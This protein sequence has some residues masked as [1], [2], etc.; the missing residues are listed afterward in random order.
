MIGSILSSYTKRNLTSVT[1]TGAT[2]E[3]ASPSHFDEEK[4]D[5]YH[6]DEL[7]I[8]NS[9]SNSYSVNTS[10][11]ASSR[12]RSPII[13]ISQTKRIKRRR[14]S[15]TKT[16]YTAVLPKQREKG[17]NY[18]CIARI[19]L[20]LMLVLA[21]I[22]ILFQNYQLVSYNLYQTSSASSSSASSSSNSNVDSMTTQNYSATTSIENQTPYSTTNTNT[23]TNTTRIVIIMKTT[24]S[25]MTSIERTL[26][27]LFPL[28]N[29]I[30]NSTKNET[31]TEA[32]AEAETESINLYDDFYLVLSQNEWIH[33][34]DEY[35][36]H[37][38]DNKEEEEDEDDVEED[39]KEEEEGEEDEEE[40]EEGEEEE[41][42]QRQINHVLPQFIQKYVNSNQ[43]TILRSESDDRLM[44]NQ[45]IHELQLEQVAKGR[46]SNLRSKL[47][48]DSN[49]NNNN[50]N[51]SNSTNTYYNNNN[52]SSLSV[53][54]HIIY[55]EDDVIYN[56]TI[57][58]NL[59]VEST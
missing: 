56:T 45:M 3:V 57:L 55:L 21:A 50:N 36:D 30:N 28:T 44:I 22:F 5:M 31:E 49:N 41:V 2:S 43:I 1:S 40:E 51:A 24:P 19:R 23:N 47:R 16:I 4:K 20:L 17:A 53:N 58:H 52:L 33:K 6:D 38:H 26:I 11:S 9:N 39:G 32:E 54:C 25:T 35:H 8:P 15:N 48:S 37:H 13:T 46:L 29:N 12:S 27:N 10:T 34:E 14:S 7:T 59:I 18:I 42:G